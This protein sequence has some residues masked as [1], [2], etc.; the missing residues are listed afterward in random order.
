MA[1]R[2]RRT[3]SR[4]TRKQ[5]RQRG[6]GWG[7]NGPAFPPAGGMAPES[8]RAMTDD[9]AVTARPAPSVTPTG[10]WSQSGGGCGC[11]A[12]LA[13]Q[14][15]GVWYNPATWFSPSAAPAPAPGP[16]AGIDN[17]RATEEE[18]KRNM[19]A[20]TPDEFIPASGV[21]EAPPTGTGMP[22]ENNNG[23]GM[24]EGL[25][26]GTGMPGQV[27]GGGGGGGYGFMLDNTLGKVYGDL[28]VGACPSQ[29]G[30]DGSVVSYP[31]GYGYGP[32]SAMEVGNGTAHF[33]AQIPYGKHCMGGGARR[34]TR[35][36]KARK[37]RS[38]R[39]R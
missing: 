26:N 39:R 33:L 4:R 2:N 25:P 30:G 16:L 6:G 37:A 8:A 22:G 9:C 1:R 3:R 14:R 35:G 29:R 27:G 5:R 19:A 31:A 15:G 20:G 17:S 10:A 21:P 38:S 24:P 13:P 11:A 12:V 36:R 18:Q 28:H 32:S 7:F 23:T 34:A